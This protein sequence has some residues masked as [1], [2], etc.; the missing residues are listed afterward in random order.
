M[1]ETKGCRC[2]ETLPVVAYL[3]DGQVAVV[4]V[5]RHLQFSTHIQGRW[6]TAD[7][8]G[9]AFLP[10]PGDTR[11][12]RCPESWATRPKDWMLTHLLDLVDAPR[13]GLAR[14]ADVTL[15]LHHPTLRPPSTVPLTQLA[16]HI[17][18]THSPLAPSRGPM[19]S[20]PD[21]PA[22]ARWCDAAPCSPPAA[23]VQWHHSQHQTPG[24]CGPS[25]SP[26]SHFFQA[27]ILFLFRGVVFSDLQLRELLRVL[28]P[29][30]FERGDALLVL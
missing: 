8:E 17:H 15:Q 16:S 3:P 30:R 12:H 27:F 24:T 7:G 9:R 5:P 1:C 28:L 26:Q 2:G 10:F 25:R 4:Q 20:R 6:H 29:L 23:P 19:L 18:N 13:K 14:L 22:R 21:L 11:G